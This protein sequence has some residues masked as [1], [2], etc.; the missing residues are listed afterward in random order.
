MF[1]NRRRVMGSIGLSADSKLSIAG[2]S[3]LNAESTTYKA[4]CNSNVLSKGTWS[5][6][7]GS[8]YGTI[9]NTGLLTLNSTANESEII[10]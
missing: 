9:S 8:Q 2:P 6:I 1:L 4:I 10:I 3:V 7:S 5:I